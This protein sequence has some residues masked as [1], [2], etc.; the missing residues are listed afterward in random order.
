MTLGSDNR[1]LN[2]GDDSLT[3]NNPGAYYT[4]AI[5]NVT[6]E[7][8]G[9]HPDRVLFLTCDAFGVLPPVSRLTE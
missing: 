6:L 2:L 1:H 7:G 3:E 5:P 4:S 9:G 8:R